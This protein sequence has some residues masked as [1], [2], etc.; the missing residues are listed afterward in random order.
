MLVTRRGTAMI[1][2]TGAHLRLARLRDAMKREGL[3]IKEWNFPPDAVLNRALNPQPDVALKKE[4]RQGRGN[5]IPARDWR[6][7]RHRDVSRRRWIPAFAGM[8]T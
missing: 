5:V 2:T 7:S 4:F 1:S 8:T 6:G 3:D